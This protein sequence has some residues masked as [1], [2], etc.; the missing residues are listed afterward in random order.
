M[1]VAGSVGARG[2]RLAWGWEV[3]AGNV[4]AHVLFVIGAGG[5]GEEEGRKEGRKEGRGTDLLKI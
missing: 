5:G 1:G 4:C 2:H 3:V